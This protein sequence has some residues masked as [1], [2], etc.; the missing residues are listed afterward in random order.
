MRRF[1]HFAIRT[2]FQP[3]Q[4]VVCAQSV[5]VGARV[6]CFLFCANHAAVRGPSQPSIPLAH[7]QDAP[8]SIKTGQGQLRPGK[9]PRT[10]A[11][12]SRQISLQTLFGNTV[13]LLDR[14][15]SCKYSDGLS[16]L[17]VSS[18][19]P[20][21]GTGSCVRQCKAACTWSIAAASAYSGAS[22]RETSLPGQ[23]D[24]AYGHE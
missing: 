6:F 24:E 11:S 23:A 15:P 9:M 8:L 1:T 21:R 3:R 14:C 19:T 12:H 13:P 17:A 16:S 7:D 22:C 5:S 18:I 20:R 10:D 2:P 4:K